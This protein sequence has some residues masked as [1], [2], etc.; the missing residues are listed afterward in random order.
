M[1]CHNHLE[2]ERVMVEM[3]YRSYDHKRRPSMLRLAGRADGR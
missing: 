2:A 1:L 3:T